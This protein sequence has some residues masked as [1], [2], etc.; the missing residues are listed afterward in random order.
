MFVCVCSECAIAT[1]SREAL[2]EEE[3]SKL[4]S[5]SEELVGLDDVVPDSD[6]LPSST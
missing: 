4:W 6:A 5:V 3:C 2:D 1:P